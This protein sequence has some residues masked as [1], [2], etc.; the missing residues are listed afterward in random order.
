MVRKDIGNRLLASLDTLK[1]VTHVLA[2]LL[3]VEQFAEG[4]LGQR[5]IF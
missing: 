2:M 3:T 5:I 1:K 4:I